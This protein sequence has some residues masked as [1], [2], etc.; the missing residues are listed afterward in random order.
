MPPLAMRKDKKKNILSS[1]GNYGK[2]N[3]NETASNL[4]QLLKSAFYSAWFTPEKLPSPSGWPRS[5]GHYMPMTLTLSPVL[6]IALE[7]EASKAR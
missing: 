2:T 4:V 3:E 6:L 7:S 1:K 5:R